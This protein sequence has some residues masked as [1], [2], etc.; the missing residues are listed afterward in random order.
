VA[1]SQVALVPP[2]FDEWFARASQKDPERRF[3]SAKEMIDAYWMLI[4]HRDEV[5]G[6]TESSGTA[7][8]R[9]SHDPT[10]PAFAV[11]GPESTLPAVPG[12][13]RTPA[14]GWRSTRGKVALI[15]AAAGALLA[16]GSLL[17]ERGASPERDGSALSLEANAPAGPTVAS[18]AS[19]PSA[20][21]EPGL[22]AAAPAPARPS[23]SQSQPPAPVAAGR[24]ARALARRPRA[25]VSRTQGAPDGGAP[26]QVSPAATSSSLL[27]SGAGLFDERK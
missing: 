27:R 4:T 18:A 19:L 16:A 10:T 5:T 20:Q 21:P 15:G 13:L 9:E 23:S 24:A 7:A 1:P 8:R 25:S 6:K 12:A 17:I 22:A 14:K 26:K 2:G 11:S 3:Q